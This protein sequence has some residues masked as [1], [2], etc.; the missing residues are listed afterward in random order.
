MALKEEP[1]TMAALWDP[2]NYIVWQNFGSE[3]WQPTVYEDRETLLADLKEGSFSSRFVIME[4][5]SLGLIA[6]SDEGDE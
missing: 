1:A 3:G 5:C 6:P 4:P 2:A